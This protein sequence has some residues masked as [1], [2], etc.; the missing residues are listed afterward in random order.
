MPKN[1]I[2]F[3]SDL[4]AQE[5]YSGWIRKYLQPDK[6]SLNFYAETPAAFA[7]ITK[8]STGSW[9]VLITDLAVA[10]KNENLINQFVK[11]NPRAVVGLLYRGTRTP[12]VPLKKAIMLTYPSDVDGW[13][14]TMQPLLETD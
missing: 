11:E 4:A 12:D 7:E 9:D 14:S 6:V 1:V 5:L 10:E 8:H 2:L 13:L 3:M